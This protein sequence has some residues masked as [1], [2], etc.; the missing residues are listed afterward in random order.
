M[1]NHVMNRISIQPATKDTWTKFLNHVSPENDEV[2]ENTGGEC[3]FDFNR[4]IPMPKTL[5]LPSNN[6]IYNMMTDAI[7]MVESG[8]HHCDH[9]V[10]ELIEALNNYAEKRHEKEHIAAALAERESTPFD[11]PH[12]IESKANA[13]RKTYDQVKAHSADM[14]LDYEIECMESEDNNENAYFKIG[15]TYLEN[16]IKHGAATW[17]DWCN[18]NWDTKWSAYE[19]W[20]EKPNDDLDD[21]TCMTFKTAWSEP[22]N[23]FIQ[24]SKQL[25]D[26][27]FTV[28]YANED[29]GY[30]CGESEFCNGEEKELQTYTTMK[31]DDAVRLACEVWGEDYDDYMAEM[32]EYEDEED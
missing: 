12:Y 8:M 30:D 3:Q 10:N 29:Y 9:T 16:I 28:K 25:P 11:L 26:I 27:K 6:L 32:S 31:H 14:L 22:R 20:L 18:E 1:P 2:I 24:L 21:E 5:N 17:Y 19:C 7:A 23:I 15:I 13:Y 4:I